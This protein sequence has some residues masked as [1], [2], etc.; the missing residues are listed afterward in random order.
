MFRMGVGILRDEIFK[1]EKFDCYSAKQS[2][3][4]KASNKDKQRQRT[5]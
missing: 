5:M 3:L 2:M 1:Y 4:C